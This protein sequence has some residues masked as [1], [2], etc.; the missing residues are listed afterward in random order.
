[1]K[2][3]I[4]MLLKVQLYNQFKLNTL[5]SKYKSKEKNHAIFLTTGVVILSIIVLLYSSGLAYGLGTI[6][7]T[8]IIP[9]Y[10]LTITSIITLLFTMIKANGVI[11]AFRDYDILMSLPIKT[12]AIIISRFLSMYVMNTLFTALVML[13]MGIIYAFF[14]SPS[15]I[16]YPLWIIG[17]L[18]A[19]LIPTT[20]ATVLG[21]LIIAVSSRFKHTS[22]ITTILSF[23][24]VLGFFG[25]SM[26]LNNQNIEQMDITQLANIGNLLSEMI[27]RVYP[28]SWLFT[29]GIVDQ[30]YEYFIAYLVISVLWFVLFVTVLSTRYKKMN[31]GLMTHHTNS[32]Y[33][34][35]ELKVGSPLLAMYK[36]ELKR[37]FSTSVYVLNAGI[38]AVILIIA[39]ISIFIMGTDKIE[40]L[41][42]DSMATEMIVKIVPFAIAGMLG[43]SCS[44]ASSLSL[45]GKN[46]WII[47]SLP[48]ENKTIFLSKILVNLTILL[49]A[50]ILSSILVAIRLKLNIIEFLLLLLIPASFCFFTSVW[51]MFINI[52][53]PNY[54]WESETAIVKQ[55]ASSMIGM[56]GAGAIGAIPIGIVLIF[57]QLDYRLIQTGIL[58]III[59][60]TSLLYKRIG[61][62]K[63]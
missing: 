22:A 36:K 21:A 15:F 7:L 10:A 9:G 2:N 50:S 23:G 35:K 40:V 53:F 56:L 42:K 49:P 5:R 62:A 33:K 57:N 59:G 54:E 28:I 63:I 1:M 26:N 25:L 44:S 17:I 8:D 60:I 38:G 61:I 12:K 18:T 43:M 19:S 3:N 41:L 46:L 47:K 29:K 24:L 34:M 13:P 55:S 45:E 11:F 27:N 52:K 31:T 32:N 37:F 30:S 51:G 48:L 20:I 58:I 4:L 39:A 14:K 6:G 16:F